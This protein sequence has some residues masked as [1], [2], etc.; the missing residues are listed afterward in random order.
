M[1]IQL[2]GVSYARTPVA[3]RE[4]FAIP[5]VRLREAMED[6]MQW[7]GVSEG[8]LLSTCNRVEVLANTRDDTTDLRA[9]LSP[10][11][12]VQRSELDPHI[13]ECREEEAVRHLFRVTSSLDSMVFGEPQIL[14]QVKQSYT[15]ARAVGAIR[16]ELDFLLMRAFAVAKRV[17]TETAI[18]SSS[19]S[20]A[21]VA[22]DLAIKI[23]GPMSE[24]TLLLVGAGKMGELAARHLLA[25][26]VTSVVVANRTLETAQ[27]LA[28]E[29]HGRAIRYEELYETCHTADI[30]I[31]ATGAGSAIFLREHGELFL[32]RRKNR[33]MLFIDIAVPRNVDPGLEEL[34]GIFVYNIDALQHVATANAQKRQKEAERAEAIVTEEVARFYSRLEARRVVPTI[35]SLQRHFESIRQ[36]ELQ[37]LRGQ[38][39]KLSMAQEAAVESLTRG[40]LKKVL[41]APVSALKL[42]DDR[43]R[44]SMVKFLN[45]AFHL[46]ESSTS[47]RSPN[48]PVSAVINRQLRESDAA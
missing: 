29:L 13:Y 25:H 37:R 14:G 18:G 41:H 16:S 30:V 35:V 23:F 42:A 47:A 9:F 6:L 38:L 3:L 24:T 21:S 36:G 34:D 32:R 27:A 43:D 19:V 5:E 15:A 12:G 7:P 33:P 44:Q 20:I 10:W 22:A 46:E 4:K 39:G 11:A 2:I 48:P 8:M 26:G 40:I 31:T 28:S 17:R 45:G 1:S